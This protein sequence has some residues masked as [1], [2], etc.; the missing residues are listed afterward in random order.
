MAFAHETAIGRDIV[1]TER[2]IYNIIDAKSSVCAAISILLKRMHLDIDMIR[3]VYICGAFGRYLDIDSATAIGMIPEFPKAEIVYIGN[4]SLGGAILTAISKTYVSE[5]ERIA[6]N[7]AVVELMLDPN[8]MEE[9]EA[10]F[11]LPGK[12][13]LFPTWYRK[14]LEI[15]PW[16]TST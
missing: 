11:T 16:R 1:V 8:F 9:Y 13:E 5:V 6:K 14:S 3:R 15:K 2:D 4:G 12:P 10:G 7:M